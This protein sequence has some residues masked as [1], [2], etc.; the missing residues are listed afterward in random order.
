[1]TSTCKIDRPNPSRS[2]W[3]FLL[4]VLV[5]APFALIILWECGHYARFGNFF[6]YGYHVDLVLD[7]SDIGVPDLHNFYCLRVTNYTLHSLQFEGI[8]LPRGITDGEILYRTK[9]EKWSEQ[10]HTWFPVY[11]SA[12]ARDPSLRDPN[13]IKSVAPGRSIYPTSCRAVLGYEGVHAGDRLRLISFTSYS[14]PQGAPGQLAFYSP[15]FT[16]EE[17][18][19]G[20]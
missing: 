17:K 4:A 8:Q 12:E 14:K 11:D 6:R 20:D 15:A 10:P 18:P 5:I 9:V 13:T 7:H 3:R 16:I 2:R 1:M 19:S